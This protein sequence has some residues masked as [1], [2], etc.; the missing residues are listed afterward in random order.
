MDITQ[1]EKSYLD[2]TKV[3]NSKFSAQRTDWQS[4]RIKVLLARKDRMMQYSTYPVRGNFPIFKIAGRFKTS[5]DSCGV[6]TTDV[7]TME[8]HSYACKE[9]PEVSIIHKK[10]SCNKLGCPVCVGSAV[11]KRAMTIGYRM[12]SISQE[13]AKQYQTIG[14]PKHISFNIQVPKIVDIE[15]FKWLQKGLIQ[16]I[17]KVGIHSGVIF[18]H[19]VRID[20]DVQELYESHHF[21]VIGYGMIMKSDEFYHRYRF[22]YRNHGDRQDLSHTLGTIQ[23]IMSHCGLIYKNVRQKNRICHKADYPECKKDCKLKLK[24]R[25]YTKVLRHSPSY[26]Y[27]GVMAPSNC[28]AKVIDNID[29]KA[30]CPVC[31]EPLYE[32]IDGLD[33]KF[34]LNPVAE[35]KLK[36]LQA[37]NK[38]I[39]YH[40]LKTTW[41]EDI[42]GIQYAFTEHRYTPTTL[43]HY[44]I[45]RLKTLLIIDKTVPF[46]KDKLKLKFSDDVL[47]ETKPIYFVKIRRNL[48][49]VFSLCF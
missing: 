11:R 21:H 36:K 20:E 49:P 9:H 3:E 16:I 2:Y 35:R 19:P 38:N 27:F 42:N 48:Y 23:Y 15:K 29:V 6:Y 43:Y 18:H 24:C 13:V 31:R 46:W 39:V 8:S 40:K 41:K 47:W 30:E 33:L 26:K 5:R 4:N 25:D 44:E 1:F 28:S 37:N 7:S 17:Q 14:K 22:T 45:Q 10:I 34:I 32:I 12:D